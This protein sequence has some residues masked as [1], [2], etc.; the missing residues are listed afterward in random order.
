MVGV[1]MVVVHF[2]LARAPVGVSV[3]GWMMMASVLV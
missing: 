1:L 3:S 2:W